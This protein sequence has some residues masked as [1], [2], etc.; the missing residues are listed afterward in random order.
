MQHAPGRPFAANLVLPD[1][2][3]CIFLMHDAAGL[4]DEEPDSYRGGGSWIW[5][6]SSRAVLWT[7]RPFSQD[8]LV[9]EHSTSLELSNGNVTLAYA[10]DRWR[11]TTIVEIFDNQAATC[12]ARRLACHIDSLNKHMAYRR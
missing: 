3:N 10:M 1:F 4:S 11:N 12:S 8:L 6:P 2:N 5:I 7:T 9:S